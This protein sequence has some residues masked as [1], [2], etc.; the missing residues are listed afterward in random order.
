MVRRY[1]VDFADGKGGPHCGQVTLTFSARWRCELA[2]SAV[3]DN[4]V[5]EQSQVLRARFHEAGGLRRIHYGRLA[6][7]GDN[8]SCARE[9]G[10]LGGD[11][12]GNPLSL[13]APPVRDYAPVL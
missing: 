2:Q 12:Y 8:D 7:M 5:L 6:C 3:F 9:S 13:W 10:Q 11:R 1:V 4:F